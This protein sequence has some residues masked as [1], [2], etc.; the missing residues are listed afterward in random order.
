MSFGL[1]CI[2]QN[3]A[4]IVLAEIKELKRLI[5]KGVTYATK[6]QMYAI[7]DWHVL[8]DNNPNIYKSEAKK[9]L[10]KCQKNMQDMKM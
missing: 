5:D 10:R 4:D 6:E 7:I 9:F 1:Q 3:T 2:Q 8:S